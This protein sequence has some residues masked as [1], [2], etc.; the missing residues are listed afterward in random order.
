MSRV[1]VLGAPVPY[2][3]FALVY[4]EPT[5]CSMVSRQQH[6][7][8][9]ACTTYR[10]Y[11]KCNSFVSI[12]MNLKRSLYVG[13]SDA[14]IYVRLNLP[15]ALVLRFWCTHRGRTKKKKCFFALPEG[16]GGYE[17][18]FPPPLRHIISYAKNP[19]SKSYTGI[20]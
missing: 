17:E 5:V 6:T 15:T 2:P 8:T 11:S 19:N 9:S 7:E 16:R 14:S 12:N 10:S 4:V 18:P 1:S 20:I 3:L 13:Q